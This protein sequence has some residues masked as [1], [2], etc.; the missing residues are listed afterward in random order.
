MMYLERK[1]Y[2]I[3]HTHLFDWQGRVVA[4]LA[5]IPI[6]V[7]TYHLVTDW[8]TTGGLYSRFRIYLDSMTSKLNDKIIVV[9]DDVR[10]S[11]V[12]SGKISAE[13]IITIQN[14]ID[15]DSFSSLGD[16]GDLRSELGLIDRLVVLAIGRLVEQKGHTYLIEAAEILKEEFPNI[17][18]LIV[19][20]GPLRKT[21]ESKIKS[22]KLEDNV[23]LLGPRRDI[24][25]L[26][27]L[28]DVYVM[29]SLFEGLPITLLEAM[30]AG[31][32]IVTTEVDGIHG[33]LRNKIEGLLVPP[34][35][36]AS[37]ARALSSLLSNKSL[38]S[39][40][41]SSAQTK[42]RADFNIADHVRRIEDIYLT[43][44]KEKKIVS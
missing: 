23:T 37:L 8:D 44:A 4:R 24:P 41:A 20:E 5:G 17:S 1:K 32:P 28:S 31:K 38:A 25:D 16:K 14:G 34:M 36:K 26:L 22:S 9:S 27:A 6:I 29:P 33:V 40:L 13:R 18:V 7:T 21:L 19:G 11:A 12:E 15:V 42:V 10:R 35:D 30:A 39:S 2:D 3:V 43:Q